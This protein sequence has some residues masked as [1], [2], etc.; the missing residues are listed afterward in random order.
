MPRALSGKGANSRALL[1]IVWTP[2]IITTMKYLNEPLAP[3]PPATGAL[4]PGLTMPQT[5]QAG[6]GCNALECLVAGSA[7]LDTDQAVGLCGKRMPQRAQMRRLVADWDDHHPAIKCRN[8]NARGWYLCVI[9]SEARE[10][11][12]V[13]KTSLQGPN[14]TEHPNHPR[15]FTTFVQY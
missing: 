13:T 7:A 12:H 15:P 14:G 9:N 8:F 1:L 4:L 6:H 3:A 10:G 2:I 5:D 11:G